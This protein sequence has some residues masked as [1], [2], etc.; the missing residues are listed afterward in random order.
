MFV[1]LQNIRMIVI[2]LFW[3]DNAIFFFILVMNMNKLIKIIAIFTLLVSVLAI[4]NGSFCFVIYILDMLGQHYHF[5]RSRFVDALIV[6][7][8]I[9]TCIIVVFM[10]LLL[11]LK[12][13]NQTNRN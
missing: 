8:I 5:T 3:I 2:N 10:G 13:L 1:F 4:I 6:L 11:S 12:T 7:Q 9:L